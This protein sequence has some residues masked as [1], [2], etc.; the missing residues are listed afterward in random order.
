MKFCKETLLDVAAELGT[1]RSMLE[2]LLREADDMLQ[3]E[4]MPKPRERWQS[5]IDACMDA[6]MEIDAMCGSCGMAIA[7][8]IE[9]LEEAAETAPTE[10]EVKASSLSSTEASDE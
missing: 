1:V 8:T 10:K 7:T 4:H 2:D 3:S 5:A 9:A 6:G